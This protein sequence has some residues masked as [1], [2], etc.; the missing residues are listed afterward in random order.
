MQEEEMME[1]LWLAQNYLFSS[2][3]RPFS[4]RKGQKQGIEEVKNVD[5]KPSVEEMS[6]KGMKESYR[7]YLGLVVFA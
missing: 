3:L 7:C 4:E 1:G 5:K 2:L 6:R